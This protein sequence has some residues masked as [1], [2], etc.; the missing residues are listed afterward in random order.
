MPPTNPIIALSPGALYGTL[1]SATN[2][3]FSFVMLL[4]VVA[5]LAAALQFMLSGGDE[6]RAASA[7]RFFAFVVVGVAV[8]VLAK[9]FV[10]VTA[11]FLGAN[12]SGLF[13]C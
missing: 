10:F 4:A 11:D 3:L 13:A 5:F 12:V 1:C 6:E 9:S 8:A 7:R 2:W